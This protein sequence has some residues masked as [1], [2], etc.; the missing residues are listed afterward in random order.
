MHPMGSNFM[1]SDLIGTAVGFLLFPLFVLVPG[2]V[3][4]WFLDALG[5][6]GRTLLA[7][8]AISIPLSIGISPILAYLLWHWS[9]L[10]VWTG[11]G[12]LWIGFIGLLFHERRL[13]LRW[14]A[15]SKGRAAIIAIAVGWIALGMFCVVDLQFENRLYFSFLAHDYTL[16][17]AITASLT[18][19]GVPPHN[20]YFFPGRPVFLRYHYFWFILCSLVNQIGSVVVSP[21]QAML[22]GTL[23]SGMGLIAVIPLYLRFFQPKGSINLERRTLIALGL[24][25]VTGLDILPVALLDILTRRINPTLEMWNTP[26]AAWVGALLWAPHHVAALVACLTGFLIVWYRRGVRGSGLDLATSVAAGTMFASALGLSVYVTLVFAAFLAVWGIVSLAKIHLREAALLSA[27]GIVTLTLCLPYLLESL[28]GHDT[29]NAGGGHF[30]RFTIRS[31]LLIEILISQLQRGRPWLIPVVNALALP[32]NYLLELGFYFLVA[33]EQWRRMRASTNFFR[34]AELC[35]F[36]MAATGIVFCT[37]LRSGVITINDLGMR[38]IMVVQFILL[39]WGAEFLC[40]GLLS[41]RVNLSTS[42]SDLV[43]HKREGRTLLIATLVLGLAGT[44]YELCV[45]RSFPLL[46][47]VTQVPRAKWLSN[48]HKIGDRTYALRQFYES[49]KDRLPQTAII[50]HNPDTDPGDVPYG[51]YADHQLAAET[52]GCGTVFGGD[53]GSCGRII[54]RINDLFE[55]PRAADRVDINKACTDLSI[56]VLITQDTDPVWADGKSWVWRTKPLLANAYARAY[57]CGR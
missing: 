26:V 54:R 11:F 25:L 43:Y 30:L 33:M 51:L 16:R 40:E 29:Q 10:A 34:H 20:P 49:L 50:Q 32:L 12:A 13:W 52:L 53:P 42:N 18:R 44:L 7:R 2:Y 39:L 56:N 22:A 19:S 41:R 14:S 57:L 55:T 47:D 23:W 21:R 6:K 31:F 5:F 27:A 36:S 35:G 8:L 48:D 46:A 17:A 24:L 9:L 45:V 37:L 38:G 4:G 28:G 3:C 1:A 15:I